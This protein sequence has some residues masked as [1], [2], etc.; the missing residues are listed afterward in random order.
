MTFRETISKYSTKTEPTHLAFN[1]GKYNIDDNNY[2]IFYK[3]YFE[4]YKNGENLYIIEKTKNCKF[5][6]FLDIEQP[7]GNDDIKLEK[8][9]LFE[10]ISSTHKQMNQFFVTPDITFHITKRQIN[11]NTVKYHVNF[12]KVIVTSDIAKNFIK[13]LLETLN[14]NNKKL[15]DITVY[16][17][18]LRLY[19]SKKSDQDIEKEKLN[20]G[21]FSYEE[22]YSLVNNNLEKINDSDVLDKLMIKR[23]SNIQLTELKELNKKIEKVQSKQIEKEL[24]VPNEINDEIKM[25]LKNLKETDIEEKYLQYSFDNDIKI[26]SKQNKMGFFCYYITLNEHYCPFV[27]RE[28]KRT[29][30]PIYMKLTINGHC[31]KC[32]NDTCSHLNYNE[33]IL[34]ESFSQLYPKLYMSMKSKYYNTNI[35]L[36]P[37]IRQLLEDSVNQS[38]YRIAK[39]LFHIYKDNFRIDDITK[40]DWY[41]YDGNKWNISYSMNILIS[42]QLPKY[43]RAIKIKNIQE[44]PTMSEDDINTRN[45]LINSL[46]ERLEN[47]SFKKNVLS[48][49][50]YLFKNHDP[51][52]LSKLDTNPYLIG[53]ENGVFD[54][55]CNDF[56]PSKKDDYISFTTGY[57]YIPYNPEH[58][59]IKDIN[60]F[61][62]QIITNE[63]VKE[64]LLKILGRSLLGIAD[65]KFY[66]FTGLSGANGKSTLINFLEET[67]GDYNTA[68]DISLLTNKR[69]LSSSASPDVARLKGK[70]LVSFSEPEHNDTLRT[71]VLKAF[72][73]GDTVVARKLYKE[74][75]TFKLQASMILICN[76]LPALSSCDGGTIRRIRV[77]D[78]NSRFCENPTKSNEFPIDHKL[79]QKLTLWKPYFMS[80]LLNWYKITDKIDTP[81]EVIEATNKYKNDNDKFND[82]FEEAVSE[83]DTILHIKEIYKLFS[84]WWNENNLNNYKIP[85]SKELLRAMKLKYNADDYTLYKGFKVNIDIQDSIPIIDELS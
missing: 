72:S 3:M 32:F 83:S 33:A 80:I 77:V 22:I 31:L 54:L 8:E 19:G 45:M 13:K 41:E 74:P 21:D 51:N 47:N 9:N 65:E 26:V 79:K 70:R 14:E 16:N 57:D 78:F 34:D 6:F 38:H 17:T 42:E 27:N 15:I 28:H 39:V 63:N 18:G 37:Q 61:I 67:L 60:T 5:A 49:L 85:D 52:F 53:F 46:V 58:Q 59:E 20:Y 75:I 64:Y 10:I 68:V 11:E 56:R 7:K 50:Y 55:K 76:D 43:Y 30:G 40:P 36:T 71:G 82:F 66:I 25:F 81:N 73:G 12:P 24:P 2:D 29:S 1:G 44:E 69:G 62:G 4:S 48:E 35:K 84:I 23:K